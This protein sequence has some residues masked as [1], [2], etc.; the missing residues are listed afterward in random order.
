[1][2]V[3]FGCS[4][5]CFLYRPA[6]SAGKI[7]LSAPVKAQAAACQEY[8]GPTPQAAEVV[9]ELAAEVEEVAD[10]AQEAAE[11]A[12]AQ[13]EEAAAEAE[14]QAEEATGDIAE[15]AEGA[16]AEAAAA[17]DEAFD[18][19]AGEAPKKVKRVVRKKVVADQPAE[20]V[21]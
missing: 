19:V 1:M 21:E 17:V 3:Q 20:P 9:G 15:A 7:F 13:V 18:E 10:G 11:A 8:T 4:A 14:A 16:V 6:Q 12:A 5:G 2:A